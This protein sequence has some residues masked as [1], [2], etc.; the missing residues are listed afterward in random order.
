[1]SSKDF[2]Q[3]K[4]FSFFGLVPMA[5]YLVVHL[6]THLQSLIG[7]QPWNE[8]LEEW[9]RNPLHWPVIILFVYIPFI[10]HTIYGIL[11]TVRGKPNGFPS[12][13]NFKYLIQRITAVGLVL[14]L[15]AH[16]FKTRIEPAMLGVPLDYGHMVEAFH[17]PPTILV[18]VLGVIAAAFHLANGLWLA[19]ITW[20]VTL[21]RKSQRVWQTATVLFFVVL[22]VMGGV[23]MWGFGRN[24]YTGHAGGDRPAASSES[25]RN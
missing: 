16:I 8:R 19:G 20:G 25:A 15:G 13:T 1:M 2:Y 24:D 22:T 7:P 10:F 11:Q 5:I 18:Y 4:L 17:H 3:R 23:A 6:A 14:F 12:F 9:H 21:S